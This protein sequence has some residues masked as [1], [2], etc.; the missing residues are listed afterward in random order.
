[1]NSTQSFAIQTH[2]DWILQF[3]FY[4]QI[5]FG[6]AQM[7][8]GS[9]MQ[10]RGYGAQ[11]SNSALN[12][13]HSVFGNNDTGTPPLLDLSEFPSLT[14]ARGNDSLPQ[15]NILQTPGSKP[16]GN[17]SRICIRFI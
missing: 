15:S 14:N 10:S 9:F 17:S 16:Y 7:T 1:M 13:F 5:C 2:F 12:S 3:S 4:F 8:V 11:N 6:N